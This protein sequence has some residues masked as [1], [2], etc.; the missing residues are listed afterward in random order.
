MYLLRKLCSTLG[1]LSKEGLYDVGFLNISRFKAHTV[2]EDET[3]ILVR[4]V[5]ALDNRFSSAIMSDIDG[6]LQSFQLWIKCSQELYI[7]Y[8]LHLRY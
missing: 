1:S 3:W 7:L 6:G 5:L 2:V 8:A 4:V